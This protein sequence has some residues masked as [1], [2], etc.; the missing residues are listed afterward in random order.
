[1]TK[2]SKSQ[3]A[4]KAFR[5]PHLFGPPPILE[6]EEADAYN[7]ILD[8]V[9]AAVAPTDFIEE[10]WV[11]DLV[12]VT[13]TMLRWRRLLAV[14]LSE[15]VSEKATDE[16]MSLAEAQTELMEGPDKEEM[17]ALLDDSAPGYDW[18][19]Q[20]SKYPRA[21]KKFKELC[22]SAESN[23]QHRS[24]SGKSGAKKFGYD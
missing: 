1:M 7:E 23:A 20:A 14:L 15:E 22:S 18:D 12:D 9:F 17:E 4:R 21:D 13:W 19:T 5:R 10:I 11:R 2:K 8:R 24:H 3:P 16:L 6:G